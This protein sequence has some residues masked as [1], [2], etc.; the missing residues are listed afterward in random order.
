MKVIIHPE[1]RFLTDFILGLPQ[2]FYHGGEVLYE[3]RNTVKRFQVDGM[4]VVVKKY[5]H[6]NLIQRIAYTFFKS[7]KT[8]RAYEFAALL[9]SKG[10]DT[11]HEVAY[12]E[13]KRHG[14]FT[15][16]YF[17]SLN[18]T[19]RDTSSQLNIRPFDHPLANALA[20]FL[21]ELHEKGV[22]HGDLNLT[23]ILYHINPDG[24]YHFS[25]I[26]TNRSRFKKPTAD[27]CLN[28][29]KRLTHQRDLLVY[30]ITLYAKHRGWNAEEC[31]HKVMRNLERFEEQRRVKRRFQDFFGIRHA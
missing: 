12:I 13:T 27:E 6:P 28:N 22:L 17:V 18:S 23:N 25:L 26:D 20:Q 24:S 21:V 3:G 15:T 10:I 11:P 2:N 16:G 29:L 7:T 5:K 1:Y 30:I 14:L 19:D 8:E 4:Y 9:R 31:V